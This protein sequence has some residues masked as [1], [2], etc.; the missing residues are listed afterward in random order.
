MRRNIFLKSLFVQL[1]LSVLYSGLFSQSYI[2]LHEK[3][4]LIDTHN[5]VLSSASMKGL[6]F[7]SDL[8]GKTYSDL[9]RLRK[10]GV[11]V[12]V[13]AIFCNETFGKG[14]AF[15]YANREI[16]SLYAIV[17]RSRDKMMM[18]NDLSSIKKAVKLKKL[19]A[20]MGV[21]GGHMIEDDLSKL[22]SFYKRGVRYMTLT[23]N[24]STSWASSARD[25]T[26]HPDSQH[27]GLN[28]FGRQVVA[29]MNEL[30]MLVDLSHVGEKTFYDAIS[31]SKKPVLVSHSCVYALCHHFRN[32]KDEQIRAVAK[33]GGVIDINFY[34]GFVDSN[35]VHKMADMRKAHQSQVDSLLRVKWPEYSIS[36]WLTARY[37]VEAASLRPTIQQLADH[38]DY[39]A[40]MVGVDYVGIGS[41]FDGIESSPR[42]LDDV[43]CYPLITKEL[44]SRGYTANE[45]KKILGGNFIRVFKANQP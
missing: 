20:M 34:S 3:A 39:V 27:N 4:I 38:I 8:K 9:D 26:L 5:D 28:D 21:E 1:V 12:Q 17:S 23:W 43:T 37:P 6:D 25:E 40:K 44:V 19:G 45:I 15:S 36:E 18:V 10:G 33:N 22:D 32:L 14:T 31:V 11:D 42:E 13:F 41:D 35:F 24:N 30:G 29:R 16:D 2:R 7:T